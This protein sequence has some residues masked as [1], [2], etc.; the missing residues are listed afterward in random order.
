MTGE[1]ELEV[2]KNQA[3]YFEDALKEIQKQIGELQSRNK[4]D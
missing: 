3:A 1:Q 2:L 4:Q